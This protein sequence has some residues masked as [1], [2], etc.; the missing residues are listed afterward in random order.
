[1]GKCFSIEVGIQSGTDRTVYV[2][3]SYT[4][5]TCVTHHKTCCDG[6]LVN[7]QYNTGDGVWFDAGNN[8][9][10]KKQATYSAP[11]NATSVRVRVKAVSKTRTEKQTY[12]TKKNKKKTK[13]V[14]VTCISSTP[15]SS[16]VKYVF[17]DPPP[18]PPPAPTCTIENNKLV[19]KLENL[20]ASVNGGVATFDVVQNDIHHCASGTATIA[21]K[22]ASYSYTVSPG[23]FYKV[24]CKVG[25]KKGTSEWGEY[26]SNVST[27]PATPSGITSISALSSSS[28]S[29]TW[30]ASTGAKTYEV[31]YTT[32]KEYF[33]AN[34]NEVNS[35]TIESGT[36]A[37]V[38]GLESGSEYYFRVRACNDQGNSGYTAIKSIIIGK[39]PTAPT[40]WS[41][42]ATVMDGEKVT[43]YWVHNSSDNSKETEST[44]NLTFRCV[45]K[46]GDSIGH[47]TLDP[48]VIPKH[49]GEE[50]EETTNYYIIDTSKV[51][52]SWKL[53]GKAVTYS[54][55]KTYLT[56]MCQIEWTVKT[57]GIINKY[58]PESTMRIIKIY[59]K[60][61]LAFSWGSVYNGK[62][63]YYKY[64][65][66]FP[67]VFRAQ[68]GPPTSTVIGYHVTIVSNESYITEDY[69]GSVKYVNKGEEIF[70]KY[71]ERD[72]ANKDY[73]ITLSASDVDFE[74]GITYTATCV[75][76]MDT[77]L[78]ASSTTEFLVQW[79]DETYY[80]D[81]RLI[82]NES[83]YTMNIQPYCTSG[84]VPEVLYGICNDIS[85][86]S[87][88]QISLLKFSDKMYF[89]NSLN[90]EV[91]DGTKLAVMFVNGNNVP[92]PRMKIDGQDTNG[93]IIFK[94][95]KP[96]QSETAYTF[97][98]NQVVS[99]VYESGRW[100]LTINSSSTT[101]WFDN[102]EEHDSLGEINFEVSLSVYRIECDGRF[103]EIGK[104]LP[105]TGDMFVTDPHPSLNFARY[106]IVA[107]SV[108]TGSV[109]YADLDPYPT[110]IYSIV[111]Q[112][113]E[114]WDSFQPS[115]NDYLD[116]P[117]EPAH[118]GSMLELPGNIDI[119]ESNTKD[120][121]LV[122]YIG[123]SHPVTYYGT[124][125]GVEQT[126]KAEIDKQDID[127]L[128]ALRK[129]SIWMGDVYVREPSGNGYWANI[130]VS[131]S[132]T[133]KEPSVPVTLK[134]TRVEG[135]M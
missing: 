101:E 96:L 55:V 34:A 22:A 15:W 127:T 49:T 76:S 51:D 94:D 25:N 72:V 102:Y 28:I 123:R 10:D 88:K 40:T 20:D 106:R 79:D 112:W 18:D 13:Q 31:Q 21:T 39:E 92:L 54:Q 33:D 81:A 5:Q 24:R 128:Y 126:W 85:A 37:I 115:R 108:S 38:S 119:D 50:E 4:T 19:A 6:Y 43:L 2:T 62:F 59:D 58:S 118:T 91:S 57:K 90:S 42:T 131:F 8:S 32:K 110:N 132:Q 78:T 84:E 116:E 23:N 27:A 75:V 56:D 107:T 80:P 71:Y 134:V 69:T 30:N 73:Y 99:F 14:T 120:V 66:H 29:L 68:A 11:S 93:V 129:L 47:M 130:S 35:Q 77:G 97:T 104:G 3:W 113:D 63:L 70:S 111:I 95:G 103:V 98:K 100:N 17:K 1:M 65:P 67:L 74:S 122:E 41:S 9:A 12:Y 46:N 36:K 83:E 52:S 44:I 7:W 60:P 89:K 114:R 86:T 135:G 82:F 105:A 45:T 48:I 121:E 64:L 117:S 109:S 87:M 124:Q 16:W 53:N 26:S 61:S 133:H 125:L